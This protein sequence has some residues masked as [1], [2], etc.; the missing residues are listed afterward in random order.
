M[1]Q[2]E[3]L[4]QQTGEKRRLFSDVQFVAGSWDHERRVIMKAEYL[5]KGTNPRFV[6][7]NRSGDAQTLYDD[8]YA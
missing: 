5:A 4:F 7:T 2:P 6:V 1:N 3:F 8:L